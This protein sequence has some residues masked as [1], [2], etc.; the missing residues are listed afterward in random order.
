MRYVKKFWSYAYKYRHCGRCG[1]WWLGTYSF[2]GHL[3]VLRHPH[4]H[5]SSSV[6]CPPGVSRCPGMF[7]FL[8][9]FLVVLCPSATNSNTIIHLYWTQCI[10]DKDLYQL[11]AKSHYPYMDML[12]PHTCT[13]IIMFM[14]KTCYITGMTPHWSE[15]NDVYTNVLGKLF[16]VYI[17]ASLS[18]TEIS[19]LGG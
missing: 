13:T 11:R 16:S 17:S 12:I 3:P 8:P 7:P 15:Q 5:Q 18:W 14:W 4:I 6:T 1:H 2:L 9:I 10:I 19:T